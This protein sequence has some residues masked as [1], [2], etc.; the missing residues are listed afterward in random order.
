MGTQFKKLTKV[1]P[2]RKVVATKEKVIN[3]IYIKGKDSE[4]NKTVIV[5]D[6]VANY[7]ITET[8]QPFGRTANNIEHRNVPY[9][10]TFDDKGKA[11]FPEGGYDSGP[12]ARPSKR[13]SDIP[14]HRNDLVELVPLTTEKALNRAGN[15]ITIVTTIKKG[16]VFTNIC[17]PIYHNK[18]VVRKGI[19]ESKRHKV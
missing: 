10:A 2:F 11:I 17:K 14:N 1:K 16:K 3:K 6:V 4:G 18:E 8:H 13:G 12:S 19:M 5:K 7:N 9:K 15:N